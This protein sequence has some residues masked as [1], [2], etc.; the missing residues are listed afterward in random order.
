MSRRGVEFKFFWALGKLRP[1]PMARPKS[2]WRRGLLLSVD[3]IF[4]LG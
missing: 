4:A 1:L 2:G 3:Y